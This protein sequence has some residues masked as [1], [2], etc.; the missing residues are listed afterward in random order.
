MLNI[1]RSL[2]FLLACLAQAGCDDEPTSD[3]QF[4]QDNSEPNFSLSPPEVLQTRA[5]DNAF[6]EPRVMLNGD[7]VVLHPST[8]NSWSGSAPIDEGDRASVS[9]VWVEI[10]GTRELPLAEY[11]KDLGVIDRN[12]PVLIQVADYDI[13]QLDEDKDRISNLNERIGGTD[14][15]D[16]EDPG[17]N[18]A[19]VLVKYIDPANAPEIDGQFDAVWRDAQYK[20]E[21]GDRMSI[22]RLMVDRGAIRQDGDTE[23]YWAA[24]HDSEYLYLIVFGA[25]NNRQTPYGDSDLTYNDDAIEIFWDGDNSRASRYDGINDYHLLIP[26]LEKGT[27]V[28]PNMSGQSGSRLA[29][30]GNSAPIIEAAIDWGVSVSSNADPDLWEVRIRLDEADI[31]IDRTF[32]FEVQLDDDNNGGARDVKWGWAHPS[33]NNEDVDFTYRFPNYMSTARLCRAVNADCS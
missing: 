6:V 9:V 28:V 16:P 32:G 20:D 2:V 29:L 3:I 12:Q 1:P 4:G 10:V 14:P 5:I 21:N 11:Q 30:G 27:E 15:Y 19:Q 17:E 26:L 18:F 13:D 22:N 25:D 33:R 8:G 23:Y 24:M 31:K 7:P